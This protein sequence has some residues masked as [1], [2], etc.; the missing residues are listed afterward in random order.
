MGFGEGVVCLWY[1]SVI[2]TQFIMKL[3]L[4]KDHPTAC[5]E[6]LLVD[7][8]VLKTSRVRLKPSSKG[9]TCIAVMATTSDVPAGCKANQPA[10]AI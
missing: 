9:A 5:W 7:C 6:V 4:K 1:P 3:Q 8:A 10:L 2:C